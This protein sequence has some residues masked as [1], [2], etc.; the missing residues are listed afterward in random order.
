[1]KTIVTSVLAACDKNGDMY[2]GV[3]DNLVY[4]VGDD[5]LAKLGD[6]TD[7]VDKNGKPLVLFGRWELDVEMVGRDLSIVDIRKPLFGVRA[8][9]LRDR[10][11]HANKG[12][13]A[14]P[15]PASEDA[16]TV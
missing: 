15:A 13:A 6:G 4:G 12:L 16:P 5:I 11:T 7:T 8:A 9:N 1:M 2:L 3:G 14:T 10:L